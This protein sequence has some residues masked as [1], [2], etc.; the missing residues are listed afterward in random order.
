MV[1]SLNHAST[2]DSYDVESMLT[3][4]AAARYTSNRSPAPRPENYLP[5]IFLPGIRGDT[6]VSIRFFPFL[7]SRKARRY[8]K[9]YA[10]GAG[11]SGAR[12]VRSRKSPIAV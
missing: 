7:F 10:F 1:R 9:P 2:V 4:A 6:G 8:E 3:V 5:S 12:S 11:F